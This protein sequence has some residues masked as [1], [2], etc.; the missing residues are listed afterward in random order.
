MDQDLRQLFRLSRFFRDESIALT[1]RVEQLVPELRQLKLSPL[2]KWDPDALSQA[3]HFAEEIIALYVS[4]FHD[5]S[6]IPVTYY[7]REKAIRRHFDAEFS[8]LFKEIARRAGRVGEPELITEEPIYYLLQKAR[9]KS[10]PKLP[11]SQGHRPHLET[12]KSRFRVDL[13][14]RLDPESP[15]R[16]AFEPTCRVLLPHELR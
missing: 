4:Y 15:V 1:A 3:R 12:L 7:K 14:C 5:V 13:A 8:R 16:S 2:G 10:F 11:K 6:R 9:E